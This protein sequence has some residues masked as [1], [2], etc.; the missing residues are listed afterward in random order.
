MHPAMPTRS[1]RIA[2]TSSALSALGVCTGCSE[3]RSTTNA[4]VAA[5]DDS[6]TMSVVSVRHG[7]FGALCTGVVIAPRIVLTAKHCVQPSAANAPYEASS[8]VVAGTRSMS[9]TSVD[10]FVD[11]GD[12]A[13]FAVA[14]VETTPGAWFDSSSGPIGALR[15]VDVAVLVLERAMPIVPAAFVLGLESL[16]IG[17][18]LRV[19]AM[20]RSLDGAPGVRRALDVH[21]DA[22]QGSVIHTDGA[23]CDGDSGGALFDRDGRLRALLS[24]S[25]APCGSPGIEFVSIDVMRD[26]I[27]RALADTGAVA[28][29]GGV[30]A[31]TDAPTIH[32]GSGGGCAAHPIS[33]PR[34]ERWCAIALF[35]AFVARRRRVIPP[36]NT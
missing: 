25:N 10:P 22:V 35:A 30:D 7:P 12:D 27:T 31:N 20:G 32:A 13:V 14:T 15:G 2:V 21:V 11:G 28:V 19:V 17:D 29:D 33:R 1:R 24:T 18:A 3:V 36:V 34:E 23:A 8:L 4:L 5:S 26:A 16:S 6:R 9:A